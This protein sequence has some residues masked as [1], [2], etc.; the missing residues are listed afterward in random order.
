MH[1][2]RSA[3]A[4]PTTSRAPDT[5]WSGVARLLARRPLVGYFAL[6]FVGTWAIL[7]PMSLGR[8]EHGLGLLP[9]AVPGGV[10]FLLAQLAAYTG[11]L[12][13]AVLVTTAT[14]GRAGLRQLRRRIGR[15][16]VGARWYLV[17]LLAPLAIW[18]A[19]YSAVL[20]GAP[21]VALAHQPV[22]LVTTFLPFVLLGLILPSL[23]EE[24]GWRGFALPRLQRRHGPVL[25]TALLGVL[26]S[27]WHLPMFFTP[28]LGPFTLTTLVTFTLTAVAAT[29][30][31][32]WVFNN[33]GGS[34]LLA[35]LLH[36][37]SNA[38]SGLMNRLVPNELP[39]D[40]WARVL[41]EGGWLNALAFGAAALLLVALTRGRLAHPADPPAGIKRGD[42][43]RS[44]GHL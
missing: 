19:A 27:L 15:W 21:L 31:Y 7:V 38:A 14:D 32:T 6:A 11:P 18:L 9:V 33:T 36:G 20:G 12:L 10:D 34:V 23:G 5:P 28:N 37:A 35:M 4:S 42:W 3:S 26:H 22:L 16:R 29:F 25:G 24:P 41:V 39:L 30:L 44:S 8:G 43:P 1:P 2:S 13:A 40:G 17:A